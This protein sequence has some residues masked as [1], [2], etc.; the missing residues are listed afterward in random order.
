[1]EGLGELILR[2]LRAV[3][4][5]RWMALLAAWVVCLGGW[6]GVMSIPNQY[7]ASARLYV[8]ADAVLTPLLRGLSV[9]SSVSN[10]LDVLQRTLLSR[11]NLEKLIA[12][13]DL[14]LSLQGPADLERMVQRLASD[15]RVVPQTRNLF[16]ITYRSTSPK[17]ALDVVQTILNTFIESKIGNN[18]SDI[19]NASTFLQAR[20][21]DYERQLRDAERRRAEFRA[22]YVDLLPADGGGVSRYEGAT[23]GLQQLRG[24]LEDAM[25]R[26]AA[27][28]KELSNTPQMLVIESEAGSGGGAYV[29]PRLADAERQLSELQLK[30]TD[31]HPD[32]VAQRRLVEALRSGKLNAPN[33]NTAPRAATPGRSRSQPNP[34]YETMRTRL[35][36]NEPA[37]ASL[38]RQVGEA[39]RERNR[40]EEIVRGAPGLQAEYININR[41]YDVV[42]RNY[43]EMLSRREQMRI[44]SAADTEANKVKMQIVDPPQ[45]PQT[46]VAPKRI[47]LLSA[48]LAAGLAAGVALSLMLG[49]LDSSFQNIDDLRILGLPVIGGIS[50]ISVVMP[51]WRRVVRVG[52]VATVLLVLCGIYGG[53]VY[54]LTAAGVA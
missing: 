10:E 27:L 28:E 26:R 53:L 24:Q 39:E 22:K 36:E 18:R 6:Y 29:N 5:R 21:D 41:D 51:L 19:E 52:T 1:M 43:D 11:P 7:E 2:K 40:L 20:I 4:Q 48:V 49:E 44:A 16:T 35:V 37:I 46:P 34:L 12:K 15:I 45:K 30:L 3:W 17:T 23:A 13:T 25:A 14:E 38:Q 33:T 31:S 42:R 50:V 47:I 8:D 32:V 54:R 9:E